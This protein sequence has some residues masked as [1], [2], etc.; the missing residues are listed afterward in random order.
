M[1]RSASGRAA[2]R[3]FP[4]AVPPSKLGNH[5]CG[6]RRGRF[7]QCT[8]PAGMGGRSERTPFFLSPEPR[9]PNE[10]FP[11]RRA[12]RGCR[13]SSRDCEQGE[14]AQE[15]LNRLQASC[16][17]PRPLLQ[18]NENTQTVYHSSAP[19]VAD[20]IEVEAYLIKIN[21]LEIL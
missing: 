6:R 20:L 5:S 21:T 10:G 8:C 7:Q 13:F 3:A 2:A 15:D 19:R 1:G 11:A 9:P 18:R 12:G 14:G 16:I 17:V 4:G